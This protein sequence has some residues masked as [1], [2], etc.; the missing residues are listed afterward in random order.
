MKTNCNTGVL[1]AELLAIL[2][3]INI[4]CELG[5]VVSKLGS[6]TEGY[7]FKSYLLQILHGKGVQL[8]ADSW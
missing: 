3:P 1:N 5:V 4:E 7:G 2:G 8:N 6:K